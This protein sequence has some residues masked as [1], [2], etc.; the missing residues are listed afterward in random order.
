M[1]WWGISE[2]RTQLKHEVEGTEKPPALNPDTA[3][4]EDPSVVPE[5]RPQAARPENAAPAQGIFHMLSTGG[6]F[7]GLLESVAGK[8]SE[9]AEAAMAIAAEGRVIESLEGAATRTMTAVGNAVSTTAEKVQDERFWEET[10]TR[11]FSA[12]GTFMEKVN[13]GVQKANTMLVGV[14]SSHASR[15]AS[16][17]TQNSNL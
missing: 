9:T 15:S 11:L 12:G 17:N 13:E 2:V 10:Q 14:D 16:L 5:E 3:K 6:G 8:A 7:M 1:L 4:E